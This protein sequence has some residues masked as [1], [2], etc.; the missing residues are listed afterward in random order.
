MARVYTENTSDAWHIPRHPT[1]KH[2]ITIMYT[3]FAVVGEA[4]CKLL[5][6]THILIVILVTFL[7]DKAISI[8][9]KKRSKLPLLLHEKYVNFQFLFFEVRKIVQFYAFTCAI[10]LFLMKRF[11]LC[12]VTVFIFMAAILDL[13]IFR[14]VR[15]YQIN[16]FPLPKSFYIFDTIFLNI[17][18]TKCQKKKLCYNLFKVAIYF[19][20]DW[21]DY[22]EKWYVTSSK[23]N[24]RR[25]NKMAANV[26]IVKQK[27]A[28]HEAILMTLFCWVWRTASM[29]SYWGK[30]LTLWYYAWALFPFPE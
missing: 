22:P 12:F 2:C 21:P 6:T 19:K 7:N 29:R 26:S 11:V 14:A 3:T 9:K 28:I 30:L 4:S 18:G 17:Y 13:Q 25:E 27:K 20:L 23:L 15:K 10:T 5:K 24:P 1:R 8:L 16:H